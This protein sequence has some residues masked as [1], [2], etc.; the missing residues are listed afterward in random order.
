MLKGQINGLR[1]AGNTNITLCLAQDFLH[2]YVQICP[3]LKNVLKQ[4]SLILR[5]TYSFVIWQNNFVVF[6]NADCVIY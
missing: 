2:P 4:K 3:E 6:T 1:G 5:E